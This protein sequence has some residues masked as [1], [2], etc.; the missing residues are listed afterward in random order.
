[1]YSLQNIISLTTPYIMYFV[2]SLT[3]SIEGVKKPIL[4]I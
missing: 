2:K 3:N 4:Y 1:M